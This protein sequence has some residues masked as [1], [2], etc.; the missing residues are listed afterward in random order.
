MTMARM[1]SDSPTSM[2]S[3]FM[4]S[5]GEGVAART[6]TC[7]VVS[8]WAGRSQLTEFRPDDD[9]RADFVLQLLEELRTRGVK[10][11]TDASYFSAGDGPSLELHI[12]SQISVFPRSP[13]YLLLI[14]DRHI[15]PQNFFIRRQKYRLV[16]SWDDDLV[17]RLGARKYIFPAHIAPGPVGDLLERP[18]FLTMVAA[19]KAQAVRTRYDL[20]VERRRTLTWYQENAPD[21]FF[22]FGPGWDFPDHPPGL[23]AKLIFKALKRIPWI[24]RSRQCWFGI[25]PTKRDVLLKSRFNLCYENTRGARGYISEKLYDA[26]SAGSVPIYW[27]ALNVHDYVPSECFVDRKMFKSNAE[28]NEFLGSMTPERYREY[29]VAMADFCV[30]QG[31]QACSIQGFACNV[32][33]AILDGLGSKT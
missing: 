1:P 6:L 32:V 29:Q 16:F 2:A 33:T 20:Y 18:M 4:N 21:K 10:V 11:I 30:K 9:G 14:E 5:I 28:L 25:A 7:F 27:G 26:L 24:R 13:Q 31:K 12:E 22:L 23:I 3:D 8:G 15:R 19:N 17:E